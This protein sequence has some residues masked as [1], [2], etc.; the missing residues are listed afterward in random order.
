MT[1]S[2]YARLDPNLASD[3]PR[4]EFLRDT[5]RCR[6]SMIQTA[7]AYGWREIRELRAGRRRHTD[8]CSRVCQAAGVCR[9][10]AVKKDDIARN[11]QRFIDEAIERLHDW[12][13]RHDDEPR[14]HLRRID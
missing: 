8:C 14:D 6:D 12:I 3:Q 2:R 10:A 11:P 4:L 1:S 5:G 13:R 9:R 7:T